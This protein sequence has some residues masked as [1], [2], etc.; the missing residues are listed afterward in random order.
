MSDRTPDLLH[1]LTARETARLIGADLA[2]AEG[3]EPAACFA[4]LYAYVAGGD[5]VMAPGLARALAVDARLQA[6]L[7]A[8]VAD[9]AVYRADRVAAAS[10]GGVTQRRGDGFTLDLRPSRSGDGQ[11]YGL[12]TLVEAQKVPRVLF[13]QPQDGPPMK[14]LLPEAARGRVQVMFEP[15]D[16]ILAALQDPASE[17]Y[18]A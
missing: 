11:V 7:R 15:E 17:V 3:V 9:M 8:L 6:D 2:R 13:V 18:L 16:P 4:D 10:S 12:I 1:I 14:A 5:P